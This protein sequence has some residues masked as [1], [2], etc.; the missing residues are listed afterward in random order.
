MTTNYSSPH[1][2]PQMFSTDSL[3]PWILYR[4]QYFNHLFIIMW[5]IRKYVMLNR[6]SSYQLIWIG[7]TSLKSVELQRFTTVRYLF[8]TVLK[9]HF[10]L[11]DHYMYF[12]QS[13]MLAETPLNHWELR[14]ILKDIRFRNPFTNQHSV[15]ICHQSNCFLRSSVPQ[16]SGYSRLLSEFAGPLSHINSG[17]LTRKQDVGKPRKHS[18]VCY[19]WKGQNRKLAQVTQYW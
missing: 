5:H 14:L 7:I 4:F 10:T 12:Q 6:K 18:S 2:K 19:E 11:W 3:L 15:K 8:Q 16:R 9:A 17:S 1:R 13:E